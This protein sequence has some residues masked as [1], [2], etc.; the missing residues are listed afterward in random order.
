MREGHWLVDFGIGRDFGLGSNARRRTW[1]GVHGDTPLGGSWSFDWLAG[2]AVLFGER[3][4]EVNAND[5]DD[6]DKR[7]HRAADHGSRKL[8]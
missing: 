6:V 2:A 3:S 4:G 1:F 5:R 8:L 7:R